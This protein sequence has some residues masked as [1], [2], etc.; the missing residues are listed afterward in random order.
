MPPEADEQSALKTDPGPSVGE[1]PEP[2][3]P[4]DSHPNPINEE[5]PPAVRQAIEALRQAFPDLQPFHKELDWAE[6]VVP[7]HL[8]KEVAT[9][10]RDD[11][12]LRLNFL[13]SIS[14]VDYQDDGLQVVY[15][16][17]LIPSS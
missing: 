12:R 11:E 2:A 13:S 14:A 8:L 17:L 15:H 4:S 3:Q 5:T 9:F 7:A 10:A 1:R 6:V 16:L